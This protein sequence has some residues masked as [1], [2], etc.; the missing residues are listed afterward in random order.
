MRTIALMSSLLLLSGCASS[1]SSF[2][3]PEHPVITDCQH[4]DVEVLAGLADLHSGGERVGDR[5]TFSVQVANNSRK[6]IV[7]RQIT[8]EE[9]P[10]DTALYRIDR[11][12]KTF[13]E[14][15]RE[16]EDHTFEIPITG[17]VVGV[18]DRSVQ[19]SRSVDEI[20]AVVTVSLES[21]IY[22]CH[23]LV[24]APRF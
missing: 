19:R 2:G 24:R 15:I 20:E 5:L 10:T 3:I 18:E 1:S 7:V 21:E 16:N 9:V 23:Y 13:N 14:T 11:A 22:R 12:F 8:I 17:R 6:D 4:G